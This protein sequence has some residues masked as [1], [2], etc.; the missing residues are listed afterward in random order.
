MAQVQK[1]HKKYLVMAISFIF[2]ALIVIVS[3]VLLI[4]KNHRSR[5]VPMEYPPGPASTVNQGDPKFY[6]KGDFYELHHIGSFW[7]HEIEMVRLK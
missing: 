3:S 2:L 6:L 1:G 4:A 7:E 5:R